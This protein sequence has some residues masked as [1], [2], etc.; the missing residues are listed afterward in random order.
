ML[1]AVLSFD[2]LSQETD[3]LSHCSAEE[4]DVELRHDGEVF[5]FDWLWLETVLLSHYSVEEG[6]ELGLVVLDAVLSF[7]CLETPDDLDS[8][9]R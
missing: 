4:G 9:T 1:D 8:G 2:W 3:L 7:D 5:S 6:D